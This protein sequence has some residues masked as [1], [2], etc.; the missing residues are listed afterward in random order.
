MNFLQLVQKAIRKS[1]ARASVPSSLSLVEGIQLEFK[2]YVIDAWREIQMERRDWYFRQ[3]EQSID[4]DN[5]SLTDGMRVPT[6]LINVANSRSFNWI[7]LFDVYVRLRADDTDP[8]SK[9]YFVPWNSWNDSFG[10]SDAQLEYNDNQNIEG[11]PRYFTIAPTG[12][13]WLNPIPDV[14]YEMQF[15]GP[16]AV[17]ELSNDSDTPFL[18]TDYHDMIVWRAVREYALYHNDTGTAE[19]ASVK[20]TFFKKALDDEYLPHMTK[21]MDGF[22]GDCV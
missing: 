12:E 10:R 16:T 5:L 19:R 20:Y 11:R 3:A 13:I 17:E 7:S 22:Y 14:N 6:S 15:F 1:G 21:K 18:P 8:P 9:I 2:N 4:I